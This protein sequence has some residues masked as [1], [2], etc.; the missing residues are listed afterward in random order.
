MEGLK[1]NEKISDPVMCPITSKK[2]GQELR[3]SNIKLTPLP[4]SS[5]PVFLP[6]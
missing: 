3:K 5:R 6:S 4:S 1:I 2:L